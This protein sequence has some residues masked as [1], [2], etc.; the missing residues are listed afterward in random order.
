[1]ILYVET[2]A[3]AKLLVD[4]PASSRLARTL[5]NQ[6]HRIR[7]FNLAAAVASRPEAPIIRVCARLDV[8]A[9]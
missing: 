9:P 6:T 7:S 3:A 4:E 8:V 1:M 5:R 2:S